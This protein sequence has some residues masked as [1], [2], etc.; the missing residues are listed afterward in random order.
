VVEFGVGAVDF[1]EVPA[2][3][4]PLLWR[5]RDDLPAWASR[6]LAPVLPFSPRFDGP[7]SLC[8]ALPPAPRLS[9]APRLPLAPRLPGDRLLEPL[10]FAWLAGDTLVAARCFVRACV[11]D[12]VDPFD[13]F[14]ASKGCVEQQ[15][16]QSEPS[17]SA[18][19]RTHSHAAH[20]AQTTHQNQN[21]TRGVALAELTRRTGRTFTLWS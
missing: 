5:L 12:I 16:R 17:A 7:L 4:A 14:V 13:A 8:D 20:A 11:R 6:D 15:T 18:R 2:A 19:I 9:P 21:A 1:R 10:V 3:V